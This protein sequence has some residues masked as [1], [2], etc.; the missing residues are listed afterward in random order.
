MTKSESA[1][2]ACVEAVDDE[3]KYATAYAAFQAAQAEED[4]PTD[5]VSG[6]PASKP[7][8][9]PR[10]G[11]GRPSNRERAGL[12]MLDQDPDERPVPGW[13]EKIDIFA[14]A[15]GARIPKG[16]PRRV[17]AEIQDIASRLA[18]VRSHRPIRSAY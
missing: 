4:D 14:I 6:K 2:M 12:E 13:I 8:A 15:A 10:R 11:R 5:P 1:W 9:A 18:W 3:A 17:R 16:V 7:P